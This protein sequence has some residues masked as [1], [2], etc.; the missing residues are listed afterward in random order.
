MALK[1]KNKAGIKKYIANQ[2]IL[3]E[4]TLLFNLEA[5]VAQL[6]NHAKL[7]QGHS[8]KPTDKYQRTGNLVGSI[9]GV[10]LKNG[11]PVDYA[12]FDTDGKIGNITGKEFVNSLIPNYTSGYVI[13]VVAGMDYATYV[14][15]IHQLNVLKKTEL[16]M[17]RDLPKLLNKL[18]AKI[19]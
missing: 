18:K 7:N 8:L 19:K 4:K 6:E 9:G 1:L 13:I 15:D 12:G 17:R 2:A 16:K 14:E 10:V 3:I 11:K 5:L